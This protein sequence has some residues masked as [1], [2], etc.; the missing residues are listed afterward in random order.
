MVEAVVVF[1]R[2]LGCCVVA[3]PGFLVLWGW[4]NIDSCGFAPCWVSGLGCLWYRFWFVR[5][6]WVCGFWWVCVFGL[7]L[8]VLLVVP[9]EYLCGFG[10][11]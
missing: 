5:C 1:C 8:K 3:F 4:C 9:G 10:R 6:V 11:V 2:C 7:L